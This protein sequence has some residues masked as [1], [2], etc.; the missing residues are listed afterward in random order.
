M[1]VGFEGT[2]DFDLSKPDGAPRN[3]C[4][5]LVHPADDHASIH[6]FGQGVD[7]CQRLLPLK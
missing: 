7:Q 6:Q 3:G 2:I 4:G 5:G 1:V